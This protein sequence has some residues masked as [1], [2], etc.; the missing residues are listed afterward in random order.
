MLYSNDLDLKLREPKPQK[1]RSH[2]PRSDA[3][4]PQ[5]YW[6]LAKLPVI[7]TVGKDCPAANSLLEECLSTQP[8]PVGRSWASG[9]KDLGIVLGNCLGGALFIGG[10][11]FLPYAL[12]Q[13]VTLL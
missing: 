9:W 7:G 6:V 5:P 12:R 4:A 13:V 2:E 3:G 10:L 1:R 11:F 8:T